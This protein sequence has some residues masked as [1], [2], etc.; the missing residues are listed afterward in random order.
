MPI[1]LPRRIPVAMLAAGSALWRVHRQVHDPLWFGPAPGS[2]PLGRFDA[3]EGQ[4]GTCYLGESLAVAVLEAMVRGSRKLLDRTELE[5][6]AASRFVTTEPMRFLQFEGAGLARIGVGAEQAHAAAYDDC[7][8]MTADLFAQHPEVDGV[9]YRS[10]WDNSL[11]CWAIFDR[12][13][14]RLGSPGEARWLGDG[15]LIGPVLDRYDLA[16]V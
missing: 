12:A 10:R 7:Q 9:Q 13:V 4:H 14:A 3:P 6:R 2:A 8:R 5:A 11:L 1:V 15:A 16:V